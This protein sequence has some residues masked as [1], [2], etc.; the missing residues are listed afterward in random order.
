[1]LRAIKDRIQGKAPGGARRSSGWP[2]IREAH[3]RANPACAVCGGTKKLEVHHK[4]PFHLHPELELEVLNLITLCEAKQYGLN[5]HLLIGH[6]GSYRSYN[7]NV[8]Q[9]AEAWSKRLKSRP[10]FIVKPPIPDVTS[11]S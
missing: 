8:E 2:K 7:L 6:L 11:D 9:D 5:C 3:L 4:K 1:M 10:V